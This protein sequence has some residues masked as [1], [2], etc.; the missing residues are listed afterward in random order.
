MQ[1]SIAPQGVDLSLRENKIMS[2]KLIEALATETVEQLAEIRALREHR[3]ERTFKEYMLR[4]RVAC[5]VMGSYVK[6]RGTM[7][8]EE[9]NRLVAKRLESFEPPVK[10]IGKG[11]AKS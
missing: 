9:T 2:E 10:Q 1:H 6:L 7:A 4:A 11:D 5:V 3:S 8:N